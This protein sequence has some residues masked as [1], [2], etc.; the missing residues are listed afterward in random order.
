MFVVVQHHIQDK[1]TAFERGQRLVKNEGAPSGAQGLQFYPSRDG[2]TITCLWEADSVESIQQY[3]DSALGES[4]VNTCY[5]VD[6]AA[7]FSDQPPGL[8]PSPRASRRVAVHET[9]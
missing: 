3:V 2:S 1:A 6:I 8:A 4:S 9:R 5:E 7:A